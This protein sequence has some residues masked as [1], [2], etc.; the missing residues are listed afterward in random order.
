M[1]PK[2]IHLVVFIYHLPHT[3][4]HPPHILGV[5][6]IFFSVPLPALR[7]DVMVPPFNTFMSDHS[8]Y[9]ITGCWNMGDTKTQLYYME[10]AMLGN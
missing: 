10:F 1:Y 8:D 7:A 3:F 6:P 4:L 2:R 5:L 9:C